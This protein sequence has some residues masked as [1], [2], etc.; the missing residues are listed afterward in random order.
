M[1][2]LAWNPKTPCWDAGLKAGIQDGTGEDGCPGIR[3]FWITLAG[4]A[5]LKLGTGK[6]RT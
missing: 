1:M 5:L 2:C 4:A 6:K 3:W